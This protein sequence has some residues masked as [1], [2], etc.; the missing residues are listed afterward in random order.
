M[1]A[2]KN[3]ELNILPDSANLFK[4]IA[5]DFM[6]RAVKAVKEKGLFTA[7]LAGGN[8]PKKLFTLLTTEPY[9]SGVPWDKIVFFFGDERYVPEDQPNNNFFM[10]HQ[11][12]FNH[13]HVQR[14]NVFEIPTEYEDPND[15]AKDYADTLRSVLNVSANQIPQFD[16]IYLG[17]GS[18]A[19]TASLIPHTDLVKSYAQSADGGNKNQIVAAIWVPALNMYRITLTPPILNNADSIIFF[20]EGNEKAEAV[21]QILQGPYDPVTYPAQ[22]IKPIKKSL[23]WFMDQ[24]AAAKL[25]LDL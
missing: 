20:L 18:D 12:L 9:K 22:L 2:L 17:L 5:D 14:V 19:H 11:Y 21:W 1:V 15:A 4:V 13:V 24:A 16:L 6:Q 7:V 8:T 3:N 10:A 23:V 25:K